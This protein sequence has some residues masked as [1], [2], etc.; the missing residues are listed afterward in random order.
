MTFGIIDLL[1]CWILQIHLGAPKPKSTS[2]KSFFKCYKLTSVSLDWYRFTK[3][4]RGAE[5]VSDI[6]FLKRENVSSICIDISIKENLRNQ[7]L[8]T[9]KKI[10]TFK[11]YLLEPKTPV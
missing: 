2:R 11:P 5:K 4:N 8:C 3:L 7:S 1:L 10:L 6:V 9:N